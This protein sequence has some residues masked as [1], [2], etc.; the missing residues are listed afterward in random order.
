MILHTLNSVNLRALQF[1]P[2][3]F[4]DESGDFHGAYGDDDDGAGARSYV[5]ATKGDER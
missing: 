5:S 4:Q 3:Q 2:G 1:P